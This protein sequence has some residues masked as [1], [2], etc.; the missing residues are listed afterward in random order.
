MHNITV[1]GNSVK[2]TE[3]EKTYLFPKGCLSAIAH[4]GDDQ[5][6]DLKL[7]GSRKKIMSFRYDDCNLSQN[8][9]EETAKE[10]GNII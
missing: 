8:N 3:G 5:S 2:I 7:M 1:Q 6:V 9:A 10:I 4:K